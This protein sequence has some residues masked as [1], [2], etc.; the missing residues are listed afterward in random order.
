M[1]QALVVVFVSS[2]RV[3]AHYSFDVTSYEAQDVITTDVIIV[4]GG[5]AGVYSAVRLHDYNK[6]TLII[7]KNDYLGG[8]AETYVDPQSDVPIDFDVIS[9]S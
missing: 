6:S 4:V 8:H 9:F 2:L 7:E 1:L 5:S 3:F